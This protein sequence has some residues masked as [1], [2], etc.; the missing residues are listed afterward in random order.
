MQKCEHL[1]APWFGVKA[2][3]SSLALIQASTKEEQQR[4]QYFRFEF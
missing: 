2:D 3:G 4:L 1:F